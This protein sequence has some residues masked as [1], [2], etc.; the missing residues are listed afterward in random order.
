M[1]AV[2]IFVTS[3]GAGWLVEADPIFQPAAFFS[4]GRAEVH[5]R[6]L[7]A[8]A[9]EAGHPAYLTIKDGRG[10]VIGKRFYSAGIAAAEKQDPAEAA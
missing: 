6:R 2:K 5:A 9:A 4:G 3:A 7:A 8:A 10:H 1:G